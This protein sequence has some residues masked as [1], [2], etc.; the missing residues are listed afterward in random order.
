MAPQTNAAIVIP[1]RAPA[2]PPMTGAPRNIGDDQPVT[3][4]PRMI[5]TAM[6]PLRNVSVSKRKRFKLAPTNLP[7]G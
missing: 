1:T 6:K 4:A 5:M 3:A 7:R 2:M